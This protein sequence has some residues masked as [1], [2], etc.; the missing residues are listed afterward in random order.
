LRSY[1]VYSHVP[2]T[3]DPH[4]SARQTDCRQDLTTTGSSSNALN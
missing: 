4:E 3:P 2:P 1:F